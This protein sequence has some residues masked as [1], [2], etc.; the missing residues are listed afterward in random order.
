MSEA[1]VVA[2]ISGA[3]TLIGVLASNSKAIGILQ[4]K[5][6]DL[7]YEVR[8]H[9]NFAERVPVLEDKA[10]RADARIAELEKIA[11]QRQKGA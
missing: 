11:R 10:K 1:I 5:I 3:V 2:L 6:E 9:N 4:Q 7:T 8:K